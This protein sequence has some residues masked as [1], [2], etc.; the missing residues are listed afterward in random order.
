MLVFQIASLIERYLVELGFSIR[1]QHFP[2]DDHV[3]VD[4]EVWSGSLGKSEED[5][6][7]LSVPGA[8]L[9]SHPSN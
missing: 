7:T 9:D 6:I 2:E 1:K 8:V 5:T 3:M 4:L